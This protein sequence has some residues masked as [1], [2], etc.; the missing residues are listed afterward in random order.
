MWK[1]A[2]LL[3]ASSLTAP[4]GSLFFPFKSF[5]FTDYKS[6]LHTHP[7]TRTHTHAH[8]LKKKPRLVFAQ[9]ELLV[10]YELP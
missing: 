8:K 6:H 7:H 9:F 4:G 2:S 3:A 10:S 5:C 1:V